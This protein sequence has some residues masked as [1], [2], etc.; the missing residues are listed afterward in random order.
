MMSKTEVIDRFLASLLL[1]AQLTGKSADLS[2]Q[3]LN[4]LLEAVNAQAEPS[5]SPDQHIA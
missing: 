4:E 2:V 3:E 1:H 5:M